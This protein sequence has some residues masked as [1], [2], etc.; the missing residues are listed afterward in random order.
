MKI[1]LVVPGYGS[2]FV[3]M[4]KE[5]YDDSRV[6]QE[7]FEEAS[8]IANTN[9]VKLCFASSEAELAKM[10]NAFPLLFLMSRS[11]YAVLAEQEII[12]SVILGEGIG[13]YTAI[14]CAGGINFADGLYLVG[15][16]AQFYQD[17]LA[18]GT[19]GL[20]RVSGVKA[21]Q[22]DQWCLHANG[23][24]QRVFIA[25]IRSAQEIIVSGTT[26][27]LAALKKILDEHDVKY[28]DEH[29]AFELHSPVAQSVADSVKLY[30]N[31]VDCKDLSI[32]VV[33]SYDAQEITSAADVAQTLVDRIVHP[34]DTH[35]Q[36]AYIRRYDL[37]IQIGPGTG[38]AQKIREWFP[39]CVVA[40]VNQR[41]DINALKQYIQQQIS[42]E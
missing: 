25:N 17:L 6:M 16:Y 2:Q 8:A 21:P 22:L 36:M 30:L 23:P 19:V 31:K 7:Y 40:T 29:D 18:T 9:F 3:G 13:E 42:S 34:L 15:K 35:A 24:E 14:A 37:I 4:G 1:A 26:D 39:E 11:L 38:L 28:A 33:R 12:P 41:S 27:G 10:A 5:L 20:L 32:P